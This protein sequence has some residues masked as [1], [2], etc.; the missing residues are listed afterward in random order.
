MAR[1]QRNLCCEELMTNIA[2]H[3]HGHVVHH[4]FDVHI[5][6]DDEGTCVA[7]KDCGKPFNPLRAGKMADPNIG[8]EGCEHLGLRLVNNIVENISYKYMYGLN[9]V[10]IKMVTT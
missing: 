4:S 8:R 7:L 3:S 2:K 5:Y 10:L 1:N 9:I 6:S